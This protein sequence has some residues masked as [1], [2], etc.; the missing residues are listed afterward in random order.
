MADSGSL[1][2]PAAARRAPR[3]LICPFA[4]L[5]RLLVAW[6]AFLRLVSLLQEAKWRSLLG[7]VVVV[8]VVGCAVNSRK[9]STYLTYHDR[10]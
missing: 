8:V 5:L 3:R 4:G 2:R 9:A 1:P 10:R 6:W 7:L